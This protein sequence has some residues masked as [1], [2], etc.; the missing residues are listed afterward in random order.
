[1]IKRGITVGA[2]RAGLLWDLWN[3]PATV[4]EFPKLVIVKDYPS[5]L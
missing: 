1:M 3:V 2:R 5:L 4:T